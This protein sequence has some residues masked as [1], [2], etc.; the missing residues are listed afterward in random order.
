MF[1][2]FIPISGSAY[3]EF[4]LRTSKSQAKIFREFAEF[5][6]FTGGDS[7][8]LLE[9]YKN[10]SSETL[11]DVNGFTKSVSGM[12]TFIPNLDGD[13]FKKTIG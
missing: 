8:T 10:Q 1:Q 5:K 4:A 9:W 13:F 12:L 6:G 3:C 7:T 2:R 11:S